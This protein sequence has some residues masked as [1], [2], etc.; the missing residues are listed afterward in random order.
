MTDP[1][2]R[3]RLAALL[4]ETRVSHSWPHDTRQLCTDARGHLDEA[5]RL[6][7]AG[8]TF[9]PALDVEAL[10]RAMEVTARAGEP[11]ETYPEWAAAIAHAYEEEVGRGND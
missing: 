4:H 5:D 3:D 1:D 8:V 7:T 2:L 9:A 11:W 6:I 10:A